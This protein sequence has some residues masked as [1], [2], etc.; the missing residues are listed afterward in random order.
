MDRR[1]QEGQ[2]DSQGALSRLG[3]CGGSRLQVPSQTDRSRLDVWTVTLRN[4]AAY[5]YSTEG[6]I[7]GATCVLLRI[8]SVEGVAEIHICQGCRRFTYYHPVRK[9]GGSSGSALGRAHVQTRI[10]PDTPEHSWR[11]LEH[12]AVPG[13]QPTRSG[14]DLAPGSDPRCYTVRMGDLPGEQSYTGADGVHDSEPADNRH[15]RFDK[16]VR[17]WLRTGRRRELGET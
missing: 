9:G 8:P 16:N 5:A 11:H 17:D 2:G 1:R 15:I 13:V 10:G 7:C 6:C 14:V 3:Q 12:G 4:C